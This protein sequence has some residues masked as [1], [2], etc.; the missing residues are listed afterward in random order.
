MVISNKTSQ[1]QGCPLCNG[2][3]PS[4][5]R[6]IVKLFPELLEEW[7][8]E[9]YKIEP[10]N[11]TYGSKKKVNWICKNNH[12]WEMSINNRTHPRQKQGCPYCSGIRKSSV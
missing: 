1:K 6:S 11:F 4:T 12:R 3:R 2:K 7:D 5:K 8:Y 9:L 10:E